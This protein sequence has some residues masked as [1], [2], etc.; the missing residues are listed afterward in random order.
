MR[1]LEQAEIRLFTGNSSTYKKLQDDQL[2][3]I[4]ST[5]SPSRSSLSFPSQTYTLTRGTIQH[6]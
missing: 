3:L 4:A 1:V 2:T 5:V 6:S